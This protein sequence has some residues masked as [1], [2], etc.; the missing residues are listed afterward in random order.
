MTKA[1]FSE[2]S[3]EAGPKKVFSA[4]AMQAVVREDVKIDVVHQTPP[5][6]R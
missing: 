5:R 4:A 3:F 1:G 6:G 2:T